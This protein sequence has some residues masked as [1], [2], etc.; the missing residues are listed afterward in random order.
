M[1]L[2]ERALSPTEFIE[3][4][5]AFKREHAPRGAFMPKLIVG[6]CTRDEL[7]RWMKEGYYYSEPA[8]TKVEMR[9]GATVEGRT[10][11]AS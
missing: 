8:S 7:L 6:R 2:L 11:A 5:Y 3:E 10:S 1:E 4:C 9:P